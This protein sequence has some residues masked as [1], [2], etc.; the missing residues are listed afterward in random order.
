MVCCVALLV[1]CIKKRD[2]DERER[3]CAFVNPSNM[4][5]AKTRRVFLSLDDFR[6][7]ARGW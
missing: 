4:T 1:A 3:A 2:V 6:A 7:Y 5:D